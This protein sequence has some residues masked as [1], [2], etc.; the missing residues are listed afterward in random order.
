[1]AQFAHARFDLRRKWFH[2]VRGVYSCLLAAESH[3]RLLQLIT[4]HPRVINKLAQS[5]QSRTIIKSVRSSFCRR[6]PNEFPPC[7]RLRSSSEYPLGMSGIRS[8]RGCSLEPLR[9]CV[10]LST[11]WHNNNIRLFS[12]AYAAYMRG[13]SPHRASGQGIARIICCFNKLHPS[14]QGASS[15]CRFACA[16]AGV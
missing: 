11:T 16:S 8:P 4:T 9:R 6:R 7:I 1:M 3:E 12:Y 10:C 13:C 2:S 5:Q 14:S 15:R